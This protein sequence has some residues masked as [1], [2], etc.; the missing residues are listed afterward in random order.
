MPTSVTLPE[1]VTFSAVPVI[2][3][4]ASEKELP[5]FS[6]VAYSGGTMRIAGFPHAVVVDL[7]GL[8]VPN[9]SVPIRLDHKSNQGVGH[10]TR[11]EAQEGQLI[12]EGLISRDTSWARDVARSGTNGFPWQASIG[13]PV[14]QAEFVPAGQTVEVNGRTFDGPLHVVRRMTLKEIS[15]VDS[16]ADGG[17]KAVVAAQHA[18]EDF[19]MP[20]TKTEGNDQATS[21][22]KP[23][24]EGESANTTTT[25]EPTTTTPVEPITATPPKNLQAVDPFDAQAA[26]AEFRS[27]MRQAAA[28]ETRR[29]AAIR[30]LCAGEHAEI[31][32]KAIDEGWDL[33]RCELEVLRTSRPSAPAGHVANNLATPQVLEAVALSA[34]GISATA[35]AA[36]YAPATLEA[37]D[38]LRGIGIQEFC[39]LAAGVRLPRYRRDGT[40]WLQ[41]AF[42]TASLPGI[43]SN[44][45][46][47]TLL[48]GYN[49]IEDAW[50][51]ICKIATVNDFKEHSRYR[52]TGS[53]RFEQVGPDGELKHG[54]VGQQQFGQKANTHGIMFA[55]TRQMIIDDD[56]GALT[57]LPRQI[58][59][60]AAEAI[61]DAVWTTLLANP[62]QS[63]GHPFFDAAH[64]NYLAGADTVLSVDGLTK[65]EV[66]FAEQTK[67][68]GRPLGVPARLLLVPTALKVPAELLMTSINLNET[69]T[70]DK[71][72][73]RANPH[74]GKFDVVS[75][76][77]LSNTQFTGH[78]NK[79]WYLMADPNRLPTIEVA[80]LGG[81][82]RP[83][84]ERADADFNTLGIQFR[85]YIDF[86]VREQDFRGAVKMKG[87]A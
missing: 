49:Y 78:S 79:A 19:A 10:T 24:S 69:T 36:A 1:F 72:K 65:A 8:Q 6:M 4:A 5:R 33:P 3:A 7:T 75:S 73:P 20:V 26:L 34:S 29:I 25:V 66:A 55:L 51:R 70:P 2:E 13:G 21:E 80:F 32:A 16:G 60:G 42:S 37:A 22:D 11:I 18:E 77:Y 14:I 63:D 45:A 85:G 61:A 56:L 54:R 9:Q 86:G 12:A 46:N 83:T 47:K 58:G 23:Q 64:K 40:G 84:V 52:M 53:F 67:P 57:E 15:F 35:L 41:A 71:G 48:E 17:T 81:V 38:R 43:L 82:D 68:G 59:M 76:V 62:A 27:D 50:R 44:I 39:E 74:A 28:A 31:E 87:E 30:K